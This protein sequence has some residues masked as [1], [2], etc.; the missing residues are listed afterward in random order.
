MTK[1]STVELAIYAFLVP[2]AIYI[3]IKHGKSG[4]LGWLYLTAFLSLRIIG[5]GLALENSSIANIISSI[6][7]SPLILA[8]AGILHE[9]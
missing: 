5:G 6:G 2:P 8:A 3:L 9:A 7:L 4:L 1:L